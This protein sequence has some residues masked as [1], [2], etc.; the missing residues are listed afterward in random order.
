M[1]RFPDH[2]ERRPT[3]VTGASS[4]IGEA[5]AR[6]LG[7]AGYPVVLGARREDRCREIAEE[8]TAAGGEAVAL[9]LD[10]GDPASIKDFAAAADG[11]HGPVEVLIANAGHTDIGRALDT[12]PADFAAAVQVNLLGAHQLATLLGA[13]MVERRRGDI[14]FV[15]SDAIPM[16]R[17]GIAAY[18]SAKFGLEGLARAMQM[19]L[20]GTGVRATVVRP[21]PTMT[22]M[23]DEWDPDQFSGLIEQWV[24]W[25][26]ARHDAFMRPSQ[27]AQ[28]VLSVVSMPRGAH[29]TLLQVEPEAPIQGDAT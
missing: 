15:S 12:A 6:A 29:I 11:V 28:A 27:V 19:E 1:A 10:V 26:V 13:G 17:P 21:G 14:V 25:G 8:I 18:V 16:P 4:G 7:A 24:H 5:V 23:G 20:E 22:S 9:G 3:V 2:P